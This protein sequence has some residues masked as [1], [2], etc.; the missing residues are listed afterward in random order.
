MARSPV[1]AH[2]HLS[3]VWCDSAGSLAEV[4][5]QV[6]LNGVPFQRFGD[7]AIALPADEAERVRKALREAGSFPRIVGD[8]MRHAAEELPVEGASE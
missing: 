6:D 5:T 8:I 1:V 7:R 2:R 4:L 3:L